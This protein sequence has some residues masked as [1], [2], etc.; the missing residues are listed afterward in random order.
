[1]YFNSFMEYYDTMNAKPVPLKEVKKKPAKKA[2]KEDKKN[3]SV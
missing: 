2:K 3:E 1:M